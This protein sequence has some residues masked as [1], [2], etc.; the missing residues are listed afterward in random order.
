M[1]QADSNG[2]VRGSFTVPSGVPSGTKSVT[3]SG[4]GGSFG[5]ASYTGSGRIQVATMRRVRT[6]NTW[7][8]RWD[9]LAQTFTLP[10]S[11][12]IAGVDLW[13]TTL[14]EDTV[15]VQ[16]RETATG[17]PN[18]EVLAEATL[19]K[20]DILLNGQSTRFEFAPVFL[21][22]DQEYAIVV[23]TD[24][25]DYEVSVAELGK[26]DKEEGWV[27][28][29][30]YQVGV[31]LS[32]SNASTWTPHQSMDLTFRLLAAK[33]DETSMVLPLG[34][35]E[36][37]DMSNWLP[38]GTVERP[39]TETDLRFEF[40]P[41]GENQPVYTCQEGEPVNLSANFTG[42]LD[43]QA[44]LTGTETL[45]PVLYPGVQAASGTLAQTADY[46]TRAITCGANKKVTVVFESFV[47]GLASVDVFAELN[48]EWQQ[49]TVNSASA[50]GDE[51][52]SLKFIFDDVT[53]DTVRVK[54]VLTG[55][56]QDRPRVRD[57][58]VMT[59]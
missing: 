16:I 45:S 56:A 47:P 35:M 55:S 9:P 30:P 23:L 14:G 17:L 11:R 59:T 49:M 53:S 2:V 43:V 57:L 29:Q 24:D 40:T 12:H 51:W 19:T 1:V 26:Y 5:E 22:A 13:F 20:D 58:R 44:R 34:E 50:V 3:F 10:Q 42:K 31:L 48:G 21:N 18:Q 28:S 41:Q 7:R 32:S 15:R 38:L 52:Q 46:I 4:D 25:A 37:A 33:F 54:L 8:Q 27:T 6:I 39:G 36:V